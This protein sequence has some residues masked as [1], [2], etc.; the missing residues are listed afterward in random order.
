MQVTDHGGNASNWLTIDTFVYGT[1][2]KEMCLHPEFTVPQAECEALVLLYQNTNGGNWRNKA[3]WLLNGDV[4]SWFG[5]RTNV[6]AG[7]EHVD[8]LFLHKQSGIDEHG[9]SSLWQ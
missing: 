6:Y 2:Q 4:E 8:G 3:N 7:A 1:Q 9:S 5:V